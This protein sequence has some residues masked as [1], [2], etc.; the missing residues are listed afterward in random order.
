MKTVNLYNYQ[1]YGHYQNEG[2][3]ASLKVHCV[4]QRVQLRQVRLSSYH[5]GAELLE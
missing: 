4:H 3:H 5:R 1:D 2:I